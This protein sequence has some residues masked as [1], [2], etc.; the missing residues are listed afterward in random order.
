MSIEFRHKTWY[1]DDVVSAPDYNYFKKELQNWEKNPVMIIFITGRPQVGKT[2]LIKKI[3]SEFENLG[4][5]FTEEI[6]EGNKRV[7]FSIETIDGKKGI[8]AHVNISS[9]YHIGR[10]GVDI[11]S[12]DKIGVQAIEDAVKQQKIIVID[13]VGRMELYSKNFQ[14]AVLHA[15][16]NAPLL[17]AAIQIKKSA[18]PDQLKTRKDCEIFK[19]TIPDREKITKD[20][21]RRIR[22]LS[23]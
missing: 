2:T 12:L 15:C 11:E 14:K 23:A 8:L 6:R 20:V 17:I 7:G 18:L 21:M 1:E 10:Y 16:D 9:P 4:G 22:E 3:I 19:L 13:E 5:F